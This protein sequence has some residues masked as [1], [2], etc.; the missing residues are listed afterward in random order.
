M[1]DDQLKRKGHAEEVQSE[2]EN[3]T[4]DAHIALA[5]KV[6]AIRTQNKEP[7]RRVDSCAN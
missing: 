7:T 4:T 6:Y 1:V 5:N 2:R 3:E